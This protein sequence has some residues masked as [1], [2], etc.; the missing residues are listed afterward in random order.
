[1]SRYIATRAISGAQQVVAEAEALL[2]KALAERGP[3]T[4]AAFP[5]TAY[6]LPLILG[7][8]GQ[9]VD[10]LG[11]LPPILQRA[12]NLLHPVP[13][14]RRWTP[15]LGETLDAGMATLLAEETIAAIRFIY[16]QEPQPFPGINL[17]GTSFTSPDVG[18]G[19]GAKVPRTPPD[20]GC[21]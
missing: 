13:T 12:K 7:M 6:H 19:G 1:M 5:N 9:E 20:A 4:P 17:A 15:Y 8:T 18:A 11:D 21:G 14:D 10:T 2:T 3:A 16:G